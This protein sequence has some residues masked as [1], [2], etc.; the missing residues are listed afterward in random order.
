MEELASVKRAAAE[1]DAAE[2]K[3]FIR[4]QFREEL[5]H[6]MQEL[7]AVFRKELYAEKRKLHCL[8]DSEAQGPAVGR[9]SSS[10]ETTQ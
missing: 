6:E 5:Q 8:D 3:D 9:S 1:K 4:H 7:R 10:E 2:L